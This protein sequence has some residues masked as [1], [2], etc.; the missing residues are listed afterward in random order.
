M[1]KVS[2]AFLCG[3]YAFLLVTS[4]LAL[5]PHV[6]VILVAFSDKW[7]MTVLPESYTLRHFAG[8][9]THKLA[10][11]GIRNSLFLSSKKWEPSTARHSPLKACPPIE[12][13]P[14]T[15]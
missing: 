3:M 2:P 10:V 9:F 12:K 15:R 13:L 8:A 6:S 7:F 4:L 11:S 14:I 5:L 1:K